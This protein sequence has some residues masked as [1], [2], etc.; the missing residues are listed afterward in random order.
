MKNVLVATL[1]MLPPMVST[2]AIACS[3]DKVELSEALEQSTTAVVARVVSTHQMAVPEDPSGK[4]IVEDASFE[5]IESIKGTKK[6]GDRI[7][8][9][10]EIG[11]GPC[12]RSARNSPIWLEE[13]AVPA[14]DVPKAFPISETWLIFG[15]GNEPYEL[16]MCTRSSPMNV[17]GADDLEIVRKLIKR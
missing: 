11:P 6:V 14:S 12:G 16:S 9:R 10:S 8:I 2:A 1:W 3:C 17:H 7:Q 4:Y 5:V 13:A 15:Y